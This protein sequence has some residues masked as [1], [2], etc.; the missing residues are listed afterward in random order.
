MRKSDVHTKFP[1]MSNNS[2]VN[3]LSLSGNICKM[4][5]KCENGGWMY[6]IE[7]GMAVAW[8]HIVA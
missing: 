2:I 6:R 5:G 1:N 7:A 4:L 8:I 3:A